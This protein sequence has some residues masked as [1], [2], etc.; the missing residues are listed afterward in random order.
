M[1][2]S[3]DLKLVYVLK[4]G[5]NSMG[6]GLY[7][8]IFAKDIAPIIAEDN[9]KDSLWDEVPASSKDNALVPT[10]DMI[11]A[12]YSLKTKEFDL[13]CLHESNDRS[14]LDGVYTIHCLAY[15]QEI[16]ADY[17][18]DDY[19]AMF[20]GEEEEDTPILVFHFG[21]TYQDVSDLLYARDILLEKTSTI[22]A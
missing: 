12:I 11:D 10:D 13:W 7:E 16:Q 1:S 9:I 3:D 20:D 19:E 4:I 8:F 22:K 18:F 2:K 21:M 6:E 15:E 17:E 14:Y 5:Y